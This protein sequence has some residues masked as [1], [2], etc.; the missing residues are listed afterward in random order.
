M[1]KGISRFMSPKAH[2]LHVAT[3]LAILLSLVPSLAVSAAEPLVYPAA[4]TIDRFE[5][6]KVIYKPGETVKFFC[7]FTSSD[8]HE[9]NS[10]GQFE[11]QLWLERELDRP[12]L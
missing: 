2:I 6:E 4:V 11:I 8:N 1:V 9:N 7:D 3:G 12:V 10:P 5:T